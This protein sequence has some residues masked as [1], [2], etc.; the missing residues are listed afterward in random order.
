MGVAVGSGAAQ[1]SYPDS[2]PTG[3][4]KCWEPQYKKQQLDVYFT[5]DTTTVLP[6]PLY[7]TDE[8]GTD[9]KQSYVYG[10][11]D[12]RISM[13]YLPSADE[14][15]DWEP[16][17]G[18]S[19]AA[20]NTTPETLYYLEDSLDSVLA[21]LNNDDEVA[22]R[23]HYDAFG[24]ATD[25]EKFDLNY[26]G[27]DNLFGYTGLG[28]D[29]SSGLSYARARYFDSSIGRFISQDTYEGQLDNPLSLNLYTYVH[30][31]PLIYTDPTGHKIW[32]VH[33]TFANPDKKGINTWS[34]Y[35]PEFVPY[36]EDLF[37][38][39]S[40]EYDWTGGNSTKA[41]KDAA[42]NLA[43]KI[44]DYYKQNPNEPVRI[45]GHSHGG[46]VGIMAVNLLAEKG[47]MVDT[48]I[49]IA[50]P[51]REYQL[52]TGVGQHIHVYNQG[53]GV[54]IN[55]GSVWHLGQAPKRKFDGAINK[56]FKVSFWR[57][58]DLRPIDSHSIMHRNIE[59]WEEYF[60]PE[61]DLTPRPT[62]TPLSKY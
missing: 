22:L 35:D 10:A 47:L 60:E 55:G 44:Y 39:K 24:V 9:W 41:R 13:S 53:D 30:N 21:L 46:N 62:Y 51:V 61:L 14:S 32:F 50:T 27:P 28:Y 34:G 8:S 58:L 26:P 36:V 6:Q 33:G 2:H 1:V 3:A 48:L 11:N 37:N 23:Y 56:V 5:N 31:N 15:T 7:A 25:A 29:A 20:P 4:R 59:V 49:T 45:V 42:E 40:E 12:E 18:E 43:N 52:N 19:G 57:T 17:A 54:Q 16:V 38:E